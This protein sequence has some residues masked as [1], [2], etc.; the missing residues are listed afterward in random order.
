MLL[1]SLFTVKSPSVTQRSVSQE[2]ASKNSLNPSPFL[3]KTVGSNKSFTLVE[4]YF[5]LK[6]A[7]FEFKV[8]LHGDQ[9]AKSIQLSPLKNRYKH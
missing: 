4:N 9:L 8:T 5:R 6:I 2:N 3:C 7:E 1:F